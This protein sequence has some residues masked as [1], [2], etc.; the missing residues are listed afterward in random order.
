MQT[1]AAVRQSIFEN[2]QPASHLVHLMHVPS[3]QKYKKTYQKQS[4]LEKKLKK[5]KRSASLREI[6]MTSD[7]AAVQ[8]GFIN[9]GFITIFFPT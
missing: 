4:D 5:C 7:K 1:F 6:L 8:T 3:P 2:G 9:L